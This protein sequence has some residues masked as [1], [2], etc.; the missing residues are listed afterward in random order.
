MI[1]RHHITCILTTH[2]LDIALNYGNRILMLKEGE[3]HQTW[4]Q[5]QKALLPRTLFCGIIIN[6][7]S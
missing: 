2:D 1:E 6:L 4:D 7:R 5:E 3:V